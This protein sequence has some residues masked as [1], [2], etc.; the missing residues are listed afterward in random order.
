MYTS[1]WHK[2]VREMVKNVHMV[3]KSIKCSGGMY[4]SMNIVIINIAYPTRKH[5]FLP[6]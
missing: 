5:I 1:N 6:I 3:L 2:V 4:R